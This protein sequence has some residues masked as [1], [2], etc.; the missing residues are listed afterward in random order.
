ML[1]HLLSWGI[2][3]RRRRN[4]TRSVILLSLIL[5]MIVAITYLFLPINQLSQ[6][7]ADAFAV[8]LINDADAP[9]KRKLK[10][11][12]PL[13]KKMYNPNEELARD[14]MEKKVEAARNKIDEVMKLSPRVV[15]KDVEV[16]KAPVSEVIPDVMT[17]ARL[18]DAEASNLSRLIAQPGQTD[19]RG[20][21]T[22]RVRARGDGMGR[23]RGGGQEGSDG[24]LLGGGGKDGAAD[25][26]GL[27]DF[28]DEFGGPKDVV[29]CL[30]ITASMQAAGMKK[31]PLAINALKDSV[32]MLGNNDKLNIVAFS[33]TAKPMSDKML[34][35]NAANIKRVLKY[36]DRFTSRSIQG[37]TGTNILTALE[38]ALTLDPS[39]IVLITDGLPTTSPD[40]PIEV[41]RDIILERVREK[42]VNNAVIYVVA[43]EFDFKLSHAAELLVSLAEEHNGKIKAIDGGQLFEF[44]EQD[45]LTDN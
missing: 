28:L 32:M 26:L 43:L 8:D 5:H 45:G 18:R 6:D 10:P 16:N 24:G 21:V 31:L 37:N 36:L 13:T 20:I 38:V 19:G 41:D 15:L 7:Q 34:P 3:V 29:Y 27:I 9:T 1:N 30:D 11:K 33:N 35:A 4:R 40:Y 22:G 12:P 44:A 42:N 39:V 23:F 25:R 17:D 2:D 14:A